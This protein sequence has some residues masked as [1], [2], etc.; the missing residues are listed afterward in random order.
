VSVTDVPSRPAPADGLPRASTGDTARAFSQVV[1][2]LVSR[3]L[4]VR[5]PPVV[6]MAERLDL[7]RRAVREL[8]R[9]RAR[10]GSGPLL[11]RLPGREIALV[12]DPEHVHRILA[13]SPVPFGADTREKKAALA[14]F[15]P[16]GVLAS[17]PEERPE[18]RRFNEHALDTGSPMHRIAPALTAAIVEEAG[19]LVAAAARDGHLTWDAFITSWWRTV[20]RIILGAGARDDHALTDDLGS[21]RARANWSLFAGQDEELRDRFHAGI[22]GHL[23][24]AEPGSLAGLMADLPADA[25]TQVVQQVPQ[26]LFAFDPG[27]IA[28][29]R[30]LAL[31]AAHP[32]ELGSVRDEV[33]AA[34]LEEPAELP[35]LRAAVLDGLRLWPTTPG[36]LR[37][38]TE[39]T[40]W[41]AG[42]M[43]PGTMLVIFAPF[44]HRDDSRL[45]YADRF[46][47]ELWLGEPTPD[48]WPLI[49]FSAGPV[50][51]PGRELV[52]LTTSTFVAALLD[53][54]DVRLDP[55]DRL[56]ADRRLPSVLSPYTIGFTAS[57]RR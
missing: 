28:A 8:Q 53:R 5:R 31:L 51:C 14:H 15:Q 34:H 43:D 4:I 50:R 39:T 6:A 52:L 23:D 48:R 11:L 16:E 37:E 19:E 49:P 17:S 7:D 40:E 32:A 42:R 18:R 57:V 3:G 55:P 21:L 33:D 35:R 13:G 26:W 25:Q 56:R 2:P 47:S 46:A 54:L 10:Y 1:V 30:A 24:R 38:T 12:L 27:G 20:R 29:Y 41:E 44:F 22:A 45:L 36:V 9:L